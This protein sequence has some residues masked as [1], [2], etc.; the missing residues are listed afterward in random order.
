MVP[1]SASPAPRIGPQA[2]KP[3]LSFTKLPH[4]R[5]PCDCQAS[6][7]SSVA[8]DLAKT[9]QLRHVLGFVKLMFTI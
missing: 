6:D 1:A 5:N 3:R 4:E 2:L 7:Y 8:P 9:Q